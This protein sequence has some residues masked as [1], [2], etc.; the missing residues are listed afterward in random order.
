MVVCFFFGFVG[1]R[2]NGLFNTIQRGNYGNVV[3][4]KD[5]FF[6]FFYGGSTCR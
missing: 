2:I 3:L 1:I 6:V 4:E 5:K